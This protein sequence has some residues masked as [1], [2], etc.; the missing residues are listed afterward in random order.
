MNV[1]FEQFVLG[2]EEAA[3]RLPQILE[4]WSELDDDLRWEYVGSI[5]WMLD[6][7]HDV[8]SMVVDHDDNERLQRAYAALLEQRSKI[9]R[10]VNIVIGDV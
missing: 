6:S 2:L 5:E 7:R 1:S 3:A 8:E 4:S 10:C 9:E